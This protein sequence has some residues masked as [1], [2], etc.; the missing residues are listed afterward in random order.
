MHSHSSFLSEIFVICFRRPHFLILDEPTNHLDVETIEALGIALNNYKVI[1]MWLHRESWIKAAPVYVR[2]VYPRYHTSPFLIQTLYNYGFTNWVKS[3][4]W[5]CRGCRYYYF[6]LPITPFFSVA[7]ILEIMGS[8][9]VYFTIITFFI[10]GS[11]R[12]D[13]VLLVFVTEQD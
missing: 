2:S 10:A 3:Y 12:F 7:Q 11:Q 5:P 4:I 9:I 6:F 8:F 13:S 1:M